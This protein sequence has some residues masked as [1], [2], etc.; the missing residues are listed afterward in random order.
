M[1]SQP[2]DTRVKQVNS[3]KPL[4]ACLSDPMAQVDGRGVMDAARPG[5]FGKTRR[6]L[7]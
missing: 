3:L 5:L 1:T 4:A 7:E 2:G 6:R